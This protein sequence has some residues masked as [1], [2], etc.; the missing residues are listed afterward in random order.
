[1]RQNGRNERT[2]KGFTLVELMI[3][4]AILVML[5]AFAVP[6]LMG[7]R[8]NAT[9][10]NT[11]AQ[12]KTF[13]SVLDTYQVEANEYPT[14]D[15]GLWALVEQP[16]DYPETS[17]WTKLIKSEKELVDPWG[18]E[19]QY[20][21]DEGTG[22][23]RVWSYGPDKEDGTEDDIIS[24]DEESEDG[25]MTGEEKGQG[26]RGGNTGG[27]SVRSGRGGNTETEAIGG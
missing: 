4:L 12:V 2:R 13:M 25:E 22:E 5:A 27:E 3:V 16:E 11:Q 18:N 9:I 19:Y 24:W 8:K 10:R 21:L 15:Q 26:N 20:E 14:T 1:M 7:V 17:N 6:Q 23:P